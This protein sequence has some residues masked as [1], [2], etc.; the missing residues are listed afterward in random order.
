MKTAPFGRSP[1]TAHASTGARSQETLGQAKIY[2]RQ[3]PDREQSAIEGGE[4]IEPELACTVPV[5]IGPAQ[6]WTAST[7]GSR[8]FFSEGGKLREY[9]L[10]EGSSTIAEG[11]LGVAGASDDGSRLYFAST[12]V[13][14]GE[15]ANSEGDKALD[16]Q[17]N[18][19]L[20]EAG[21]EAGEGKFSFIGA[22]AS[23]DFS[24]TL[25]TNSP[26]NPISPVPARRASR[27]SP[28]GATLAFNS[29]SRPTGYDSTDA[30]SGEADTE[31]FLYSA[32]DD[33]LDCVSCNPSGARPAGRE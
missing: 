19:Y 32:A 23:R 9:R 29:Y 17:P 31:V 15:D 7:D 27:V 20:Y 21:E 28:D 8:A 10:E 1:K 13:L 22:L 30:A 16:G 24:L 33:E 26:L 12:K 3:H 6:F 14:S 5:S 18:L 4:C 11:V 2:L 25:T